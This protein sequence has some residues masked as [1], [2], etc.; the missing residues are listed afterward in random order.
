MRL[1]DLRARFYGCHFPGDAAY[2]DGR[3]VTFECPHCAAAGVP[4]D[5]RQR[6]GV[7]FANP[8]GGGPKVAGGGEQGDCWWIRTGDTID[9]LTLAPSVDASSERAGRHWHGHVVNGAC[10]P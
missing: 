5:E 7:P 6:L 1:T 2:Y 10:V 4:P 9:A 3:G 8:I